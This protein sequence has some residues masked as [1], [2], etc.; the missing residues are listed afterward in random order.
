[1][2]DSHEAG[3]QQTPR[4]AAVFVLLAVA[5][6]LVGLSL[7]D[8]DAEPEPPLT[9]TEVIRF[10]PAL[11]PEDSA[12]D[13]PCFTVSLSVNGRDDAWRCTLS[14]TAG[15]GGDSLFDPC[16]EAEP[17]IVVCEADPVAGEPGFRLR[18]AQPLPEWIAVP[19][20]P[21]QYWLLEL[22]DGTSCRFTA[23]ATGGADG[24]RANYHC[25]DGRWLLGHVLPGELLTARRIDTDD[26]SAAGFRIE[27]AEVVAIRRAWR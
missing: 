4:I 12:R 27:D 24:E 1:V 17:G 23:G 8:D 21:Q 5:A 20:D 15:S 16:F 10:E 9:S 13:G 22:E 19:Q 18:L 7:L 11:P 2:T 3:T 25:S 6:M 14:G 26:A